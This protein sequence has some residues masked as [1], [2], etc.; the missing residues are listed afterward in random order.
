LRA[1]IGSVEGEIH[2]GLLAGPELDEVAGAEPLRR[3][4]SLNLRCRRIHLPVGQAERVGFLENG[5]SLARGAEREEFQDR[6][7]GDHQGEE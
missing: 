3:G 1:W 6:V 7:V 4:H 2:H 5:A